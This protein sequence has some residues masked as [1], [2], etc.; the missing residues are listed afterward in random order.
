MSVD[1]LSAGDTLKC[2]ASL[3]DLSISI[4]NGR[5]ISVSAIVLLEL[6]GENTYMSSAAAEIE[7]D[8]VC[9]LKKSIGMLRLSKIREIY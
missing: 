2:T 9:C 7:N 6:Y 8:D 1:G 5:K 3:E 4:I